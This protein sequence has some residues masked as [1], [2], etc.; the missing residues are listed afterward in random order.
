[1]KME[2]IFSVDVEDWFHILDIVSAP[3]LAQWNSLPSRVEKNFLKLLDIFSEYNVNITCFFLGP[4]AERYPHLV[5]EAAS[6]G[7]EI[8][9][10]GYSHRLVYEMTPAQFLDDASISRDLLENIIGAPVLG[11]RAAG[12]SVTRETPWFF[13]NLIAAGYKYDS[14][15]FP[16]ERGHGGFTGNPYAPYVERRNG[17]EIV[18]FPITVKEVFGKA[19]CFFGGGYLRLFPYFII[20][21][22]AMAVDKESRPVVFYVHPREIDPH[23]PRLPMPL[24]RAFKSYVNLKSTEGK[25]RRILSDFR[26]ST[27]RHF[28]NDN[29]N[30]LNSER[31]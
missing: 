4:V 13:D 27:F 12:F 28:M 18:E 8:A 1:M 10:H 5:K 23:H 30:L 9:S 3:D 26:V 17:E 14:S 16:A 15:V 29:S 2:H 11:Y 25:I 7:H 19:S 21:R 24:A 20:K 31:S 6:R 22:M